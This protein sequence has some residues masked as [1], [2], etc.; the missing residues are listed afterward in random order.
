MG[1]GMRSVWRALPPLLRTRR[2]RGGLGSQRLGVFVTDREVACESARVREKRV[3]DV[4]VL[5]HHRAILFGEA[6]AVLREKCRALVGWKTQRDGA[7]FGE[8]AEHVAVDRGV[9]HRR[10]L[11]L[12]FRY[13]RHKP[14]VESQAVPIA[15]RNDGPR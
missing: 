10:A 4:D 8:Q 6:R 13:R 7:F 3:R 5:L 15:W 9:R 1:P 11:P 2:A 12:D 14:F